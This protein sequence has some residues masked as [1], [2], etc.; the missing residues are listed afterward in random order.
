MDFSITDDEGKFQD[1]V[2]G[3]MDRYVTEAVLDRCHRTGTM[4]DWTL[5]PRSR[6]TGLARLVLAG[7]GRGPGS[8][9]DGGRPLL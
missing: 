9:P 6:S 4:H 1:E 8:I 3:F 5:H 2:R 7:R